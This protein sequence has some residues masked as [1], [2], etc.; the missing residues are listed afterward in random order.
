MPATLTL[1]LGPICYVN[2]SVNVLTHFSLILVNLP[3]KHGP[4]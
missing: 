2:T 4:H 1:K 3:Q